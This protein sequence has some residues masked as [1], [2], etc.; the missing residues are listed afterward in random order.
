MAAA[1]RDISREA[2]WKV[3]S[4]LWRRK[5]YST[6]EFVELYKA[7]VLS[8]IESRTPGL[9]HAAPSVLEIVDR[10]QGRFLREIRFSELEAFERFRLAPL[11]DRRD[12]SMLGLLHRVSLGNVPPPLAALFDAPVARPFAGRSVGTRAGAVR[13]NRQFAEHVS[14]GGRMEVFR[15]SCFGLVAIR[16]MLPESAA[17]TKHQSGAKERRSDAFRIAPAMSRIVIGNISSRTRLVS[18][19]CQCFSAV[20]T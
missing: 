10:V 4:L 9:H 8:F 7:Q 5:C 12:I 11:P 2:G 20:C 6:P 3:R 15:K 18:C 13:H 19:Q 17:D 1:V 16:N 14:R